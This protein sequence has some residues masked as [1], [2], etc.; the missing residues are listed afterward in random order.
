M[1]TLNSKALISLYE[2]ADFIDGDHSSTSKVVQNSG[3]YAS[4]INQAS[5]TFEF[6]TGRTFMS[7]S[8]AIE[9]FQGNCYHEYYLR[10]A[11]VASRFV[12]LDYFTGN[13]GVWDNS[14]T[15][16]SY[17][18]THDPITG[19]VYFIDGANFWRSSALENNWRA[20]YAY[21]YTTRSYVPQD[22]KYAVCVMT[23]RIYERNFTQGKNQINIGGQSYSYPQQWPEDVQ[24]IIY[25]YIRY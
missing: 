19:R 9:Y 12:K 7:G 11:P 15:S 16:G 2:L 5:S 10:Q 14:I 8:L 1:A 21:G 18:H 6:L 4:A 23:Q 13:T 22:I 17:E 25:R 24:E 3:S 20:T